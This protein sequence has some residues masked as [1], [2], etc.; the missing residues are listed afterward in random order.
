[1]GAVR[2][3]I[4]K[5]SDEDEQ[6]RLQEL[7]A[8]NI[9]DTPSEASFDR[10]TRLVADVLQVPICLISLIT[11]DRLWFKSCYGLQEDLVQARSTEREAALVNTW[12]RSG[13]LS[14]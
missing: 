1:M 10:I 2:T 6:R 4:V 3:N 9:V 5:F 7:Y 8:L 11:E 14:L 12:L 13:S